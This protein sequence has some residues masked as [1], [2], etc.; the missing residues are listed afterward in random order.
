MRGR[1]AICARLSI[2]K[3][4]TVSAARIISNVAGSSFGNRAKSTGCPRAAQISSVSC[5]AAIMP[6]P[7]RSTLMM[8]MSSQS[9]LSHCS[10]LRPGI[11][12]FSSGTYWERFPALS[13]MPPE[14]CPRWRGSPC[15]C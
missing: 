14:C 15:T 6:S 11:R 10:T 13:T 2:W 3:T 4:P 12:A 9:L 5:I 1:V 7:S 8:P